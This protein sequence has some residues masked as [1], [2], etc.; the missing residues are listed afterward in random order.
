MA[1]ISASADA[2]QIP[3]TNELITQVIPAHNV[4]AVKLRQDLTPLIG[5]DADMVY[6]DAVDRP[7][8]HVA[9][10]GECRLLAVLHH[11]RVRA[12]TDNTAARCAG[13]DRLSAAKPMRADSLQVDDLI[14]KLK[15]AKMD[16][17]A[18]VP[19]AKGDKV[20]TVS[21]SD[22]LG[23]QT[24]DVWKAKDNSYYAKS[25]VVPGIYK[26]AGDLGDS[27]TK[28]VEDFRNKKLTTEVGTKPI[29]SFNFKRFKQPSGRQF[30]TTNNVRP[31]FA[32]IG[33]ADI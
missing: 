22:N 19:D 24:L 4:D 2:A 28:G 31:N 14:R 33:F 8:H 30:G 5:A 20:G 3:A 23:T 32:R 25:S 6:A 29:Y 1:L 7:L 16:P 13:L 27:F 15:D 17:A 21:T 10:L 12:Q 11:M 9:E 18:T 26:L